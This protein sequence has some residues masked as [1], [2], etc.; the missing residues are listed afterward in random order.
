MNLLRNTLLLI[1]LTF[2]SQPVCADIVIQIEDQAV[3]Q[4]TPNAVVDVLI[5]S[6]RGDDPIAIAGDF[7]ILNATFSDPPGAFDQPGFFNAGNYNDASSLLLDPNDAS[8]AFMSL[9]IDTPAAIPDVDAILV[10]L[11]VDSASL[12]PGEY[13]INLAN[14]LALNSNGDVPNTVGVAGTLT[15]TAIPEPSSVFVLGT[16]GATLLMRRRRRA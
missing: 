14:T 3:S 7:R 9:D 10:Q 16:A 8:L 2:I 4:G 5:R 12:T 1:F 6:D 11:F 15:I 13:E